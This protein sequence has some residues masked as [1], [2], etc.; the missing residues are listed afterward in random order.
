MNA[1]IARS[2]KAIND[3]KINKYPYEGMEPNIPEGLNI[4]EIGNEFFHGLEDLGIN[5]MDKICFV[6]ITCDTYHNL[7]NNDIILNLP[8]DIIT[9]LS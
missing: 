1:Y 2:K 9:K 5:N 3:H 8:V 7:L 4:N 6:L